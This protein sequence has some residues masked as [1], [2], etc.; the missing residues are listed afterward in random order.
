MVSRS[1]YF[2]GLLI[3]GI[4]FIA[5]GIISI[6]YSNTSVKVDV[7]G[8]IK[9]NAVDILSPNMEKGDSAVISV[10][11]SRF[12]MSIV[13]PNKTDVTLTESSSAYSFNLTATQ[14]GEYFIKINNFGNDDILVD[15]YA[16]TKGNNLSLIG[17]I[18]LII[19][20]IVI[21]ALGLRTR[22][23]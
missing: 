15:G 9:P 12:N 10:S 5:I 2:Y 18:M 1:L 16:F 13:Y 22:K 6:Y 19:T 23:M 11:G 8:I 17:Q 20:G 4:V 3:A 7:D 21:A 14:D